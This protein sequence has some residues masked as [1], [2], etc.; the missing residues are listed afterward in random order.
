[1]NSN[2]TGEEVQQGRN[3]K[4]AQLEVAVQGVILAFALVGNG[5]VLFA[6]TQHGRKITRLRFCILHLAI[7]DI[8]VALFNILP[9][10]IWDITYRFQGNDLLCRLVKFAQV[11]VMYL[12]TYILVITAID[13]YI[14]IC[15][16]F[17]FEGASKRRVKIMVIIAWFL[18][19]AFSAPQTIIFKYQLIDPD[20]MTF[21]CWAT[22]QPPWTMTAYI[23]CFTFLIYIIPLAILVYTYGRIGLAVWGGC[24]NPT[25]RYTHALAPTHVSHV[26]SADTSATP[27]PPSSRPN[28]N[29]QTFTDSR[30]FFNNESGKSVPQKVIKTIRLTFVVVIAYIICWSPFFVT[31]LW[32]SYDTSAPTDSGV[33]VIMLLLAS[34]NSCCNPWI[35]LVF[36]GGLLKSSLP[37]FSQHAVHYNGA[38]RPKVKV[39]FPLKEIPIQTVYFRSM[40]KSP[41]ERK[42]PQDRGYM[43]AGTCALTYDT[44]FSDILTP[45]GTR[46][47]CVPK[48]HYLN[49]ADHRPLAETDK[50]RAC[51]NMETWLYQTKIWCAH[52]IKE[53][54]VGLVLRRDRPCK[55][56]LKISC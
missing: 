21:D 26:F 45:W 33:F 44:Q 13:R 6:L 52:L 7:A 39:R 43:C 5:L 14:A 42:C 20:P 4:L 18:A 12:S 10:M 55:I 22:F 17:Y 48:K 56:Y 34:L 50:R 41:W 32:W 40:R 19:I 1:M 23:T 49:H 47:R 31:Q 16:P 9:Q 46:T 11:F 54:N 53:R 29:E 36:S 30:K 25:H 15:H 27:S 28:L 35:Y 8:L 2:S 3:E 38:K 24:C 37:C 51:G